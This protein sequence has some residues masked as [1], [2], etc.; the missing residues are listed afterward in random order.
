M[1]RD[2]KTCEFRTAGRGHDECFICIAKSDGDDDAAGWEHNAQAK[3][4]K[5]N[6][7]SQWKECD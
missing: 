5:S 7:K 4:E 6:Q 3:L 2:C 1:D